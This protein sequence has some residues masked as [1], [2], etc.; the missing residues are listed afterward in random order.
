MESSTEHGSV[1]LYCDEKEIR[2]IIQVATWT[3]LTMV[4]NNEDGRKTL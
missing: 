3:N 2:D 1:E 4:D